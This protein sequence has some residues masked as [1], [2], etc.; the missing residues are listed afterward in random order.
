MAMNNK[1]FRALLH[2]LGCVG[3]MTIPILFSPDLTGSRNL[4]TIPPFQRDLFHFALLIGFF[5]LNYFLLVPQFYFNRRF[6][7]FFVISLGALFIAEFL[8]VFF[9]PGKQPFPPP[10]EDGPHPHM[11][12][13]IYA[14]H[15]FQFLGMM[16]FSLLLRITDRWKKAEQ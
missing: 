15:L 1:A 5:Y 11:Q 10:D 14:N 4:F 8:P 9:F 2:I 6:A 7:V 12:F 13:F 3:F 16:L